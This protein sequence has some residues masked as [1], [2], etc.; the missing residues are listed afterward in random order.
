MGLLLSQLDWPVNEGGPQGDRCHM[1]PREAIG[2][3][4]WRRLIQGAGAYCVTRTVVHGYGDDEE[5]VGASFS[6]DK[7]RSDGVPIRTEGTL[8]P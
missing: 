1:P 3:L 7:G 8:Q 2:T 6:S 5:G 4:A